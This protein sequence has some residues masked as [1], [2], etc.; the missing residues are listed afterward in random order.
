MRRKITEQIV[1]LAILISCSA[2]A[3]TAALPGDINVYVTGNATYA[4]PIEVVPG[5]NGM[6]PALSLVYN[7]MSGQGMLGQ[8]WNLQGTSA[9]TRAPQTLY[10]DNNVSSVVFDT[11]DR[12]MLDGSRLL[13][14]SGTSYFA[15]DAVYCFEEETPS[16]VEM[17]TDNEG[18]PY[19][20]QS[21]PDGKQVYY[22]ESADTRYAV[23][24]KVYS[25]L[26]SRVVDGNDNYM[27]FSYD[28]DYNEMWLTSI[29]Y[30][31]N[32]VAEMTSYAQVQFVYCTVPLSNEAYVD[33]LPLKKSKLLQDVIVKYRG[34]VVR[35]Y[36]LSYDTDLQYPRLSSVS[37]HDNMGVCLTTTTITWD[38][39]LSNIITED[40]VSPVNGTPYVVAG[41]F[42]EDRIY[43]IFAVYTTNNDIY[44]YIY[45]RSADGSFSLSYV[46]YQFMHGAD[47]ATMTACD[48]DNDGV[49]EI[50]YSTANGRVIQ[51]KIDAA[52]GNATGTVIAQF[53][54]GYY[55]LGDFDGDGIVEVVTVI[56]N[57][58]LAYYNVAGQTDTYEMPGT[59]YNSLVGDYDGD[60]KADLLMVGIDRHVILSFDNRLRRWVVKEPVGLPL[61]HLVCQTGDFNGDGVSDIIFS[62]NGSTDW[63]VAIHGGNQRWYLTGIPEMDDYSPIICDINGDGKSDIMAWQTNQVKYFISQGVNHSSFRY[64]SPQSFSLSNTQFFM[65]GRYALGDF[66][67]SGTPDI[68]FSSPVTASCPVTIKYFYRDNLSCNFVSQ[69][70]DA[71]GKNIRLEYSS[72]SLA[73]ALYYGSDMNWIPCPIVKSVMS[74][75]G[76][77]GYDT[78]LFFYRDVLYH[79]TKRQFV[80]FSRFVTRKNGVTTESFFSMPAGEDHPAE[81]LPCM[82]TDSVVTYKTPYYMYSAPLQ[83]IGDYPVWHTGSDVTISRIKNYNA[84]RYRQVSGGV[85][86]FPYVEKCVTTDFL[87]NTEDSVVVAIDQTYPFV[88]TRGQYKKYNRGSSET[89]YS[90]TSSY[91]YEMV[92][93]SNGHHKPVLVREVSVVR[94]YPREDVIQLRDTLQYYYDHGMLDH[95]RHMDNGGLSETKTYTYNPCGMPVRTTIEPYGETPRYVENG[96]DATSRFVEEQVNHTG[97]MQ[98]FTYDGATGALLT[99]SDVN[100][101]VTQYEYDA[102]GRVVRTLFPDGT[103]QRVEYY[104]GNGGLDH[105]STYTEIRETGKADK[106]VYYDVL[107]R[108]VHTYVEDLGY[109]DITYNRQGNV[110]RKT[111]VPYTDANATFSSK[112]WRTYVYNSLGRLYSESAIDQTITHTYSAMDYDTS[113]YRYSETETSNMGQWKRTTYDAAGNV[114]Q[115]EDNGGTVHYDCRYGTY[116]SKLGVFQKIAIGEDTTVIVTDSRGNRMKLV[117]PDAGTITSVYNGWNELVSQTDANGNTTQI[118]Y[119]NMG[120]K[121]RQTWSAHLGYMN[122]PYVY[123]YNTDFTESSRGKG[124]LASIQY[125]NITLQSFEY[126]RYG[127]VAGVTKY[128]EGTPYTESYTYN[129]SGQLYTKTVPDGFT[130]RYLYDI[131]G[132]VDQIKDHQTGDEIYSVYRRTQLGVPRVCWFGN[133]TGVNYAYDPYGRLTGLRYGYKEQYTPPTLHGDIGD[134]VIDPDPFQEEHDP[135]VVGD[136]YSSVVYLYNDYGYLSNRN[137]MKVNQQEAYY[138]DAAGRLSRYVVNGTNEYTFA[139]ADNGNMTRNSKVSAYDYSYTYNNDLYPQP[140]AVKGVMARNGVVAPTRCDVT[141][142]TRNRPASISENGWTLTLLYGNGLQREKEVLKQGNSTVSTTYFISRDCEREIKSSVSRYIDYIYADGRIVAL[143]VY[144]ETADAD[145]IYY[146]QT[147]YLGSWERVVDCNKAVVQSSHFDPW[148]NRM[149]ATDW[150]AIQDGSGFGFHRGFAGHEH[151]DRFGII[152]MNARLYDPVIGRF[153]SPDPQVQ[154]PY[155]TQGFNR[156]SYCGNNPVMFTDPDGELFGTWLLSFIHGFFST[157]ENRWGTAWNTAN[158]IVGNEIKIIGGLFASDPNKSF[159]GQLWEVASRF[160]WQAPQTLIGFALSQFANASEW[161]GFTNGGIQSIDY[162]YGATV[163]SYNVGG[164]GAVT[165]GN[166]INGSSR[167]EADPNNSLFQHEYGH[168]IQSQEMGIAYLPRVGIPSILSSGPEHD[169]HPVE[170]DANRRAFMY[171]NKYVPGFYSTEE[172]WNYRNSEEYKG[173][174]FNRNPLN[175]NGEFFDYQSANFPLLHARWY[176]YLSWAGG[177][178]GALIEGLCLG[179]FYNNIY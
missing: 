33:N 55:R 114:A 159:L 118:I 6:Q 63:M 103:T 100:E 22:G 147:D 40:T 149:S 116:N 10:F 39:P 93:T 160:T 16:R 134:I 38:T 126:D 96:Y 138:Y 19:F 50:I 87:T 94:Q 99:Q 113:N 27:V 141:Y 153:F 161:M 167:L 73:H 176:D 173:W 76:V 148:G 140:H 157:G 142:N 107:G 9:I 104:V 83:Y 5:T 44:P 53:M 66:D 20:V 166:Y 165:L 115:V 171:F 95:C 154:S 47:L 26:V 18:A 168:Y 80:G 15:D 59:F 150:T 143:H 62:A 4:I 123:N 112:K 21:L 124:K 23:D 152:N 109:H 177:P 42:D 111:I 90:K 121:T 175:S 97:D 86:Y 128:I 45:K 69:I 8:K 57:R 172:E 162:L 56:A 170:I 58:Y 137:D 28:R 54:D 32:D 132:S 144:N 71:I 133:N 37:L 29:D 85:Q 84:C 46:N 89:V 98:Q 41:N 75:N 101:L 17:A 2:K 136:Q 163:V 125:G 156:Y 68:L 1:L 7:S 24:G 43:D 82:V 155:S 169:Y 178:F 79:A 74:S 130:L 120:R 51:V 92:V 13:L 88:E 35:R 65:A 12:L 102:F 110:V 131:Y 108:T 14:Y 135:Y 70:T 67:G 60:G 77:D 30:T 174:Y 105:T 25:W 11:S 49:D 129:S 36:H 61:N 31:Y 122:H 3:Q 146:V 127:R 117:D 48:M 52:T 179:I 106:M 91:R 145:S 72:I 119:D 81:V 164:W 34:D 64:A 151:Y 78:T 158:R 139:Y